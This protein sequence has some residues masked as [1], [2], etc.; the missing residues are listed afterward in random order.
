VSSVKGPEPKRAGLAQSSR[1]LI[2]VLALAAMLLVASFASTPARAQEVPSDPASEATPVAP[3]TTTDPASPP[4][5]P[6]SGSTVGDPAAPAQPA[7]P[8]ADQVV[9]QDPGA[10]DASTQTPQSTQDDRASARQPSH[11]GGGGGQSNATPAPSVPS[12]GEDTTTVETVAPSS[13]GYPGAWSGQDTFVVDK[14]DDRPTGAASGYS[15]PRGPFSGLYVLR[16]ASRAS[17]LE[18][19]ARRSHTTAQVS[20]LGAP[21]GS[22]HQLPSHNPFFNLL[23][24]PGGSVAGLA[25]VSVLAILGVA[26][27]L[28]RDRLRVFRMPTATWRP[29]AYVPPIEL[30]G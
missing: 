17:G 23:S 6:D 20:A 9:P 25:L 28:P 29:S 3:P 24:G 18:A 12:T 1:R 26:F 30:P 15:G 4:I 27:V 8:P 5:V 10:G 22:G 13:D 21:P 14:T 7:D 11:N 2:R 19:K 16:G